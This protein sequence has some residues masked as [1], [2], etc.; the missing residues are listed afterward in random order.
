MFSSR[1]LLLVSVFV[2]SGCASTPAP[3]QAQA[4]TAESAAVPVVPVVAAPVVDPNDPEYL[5]LNKLASEPWGFRRDFWNT[6]HI[7]LVDWKNW[8]RTRII[9]NPTRA[10]FRY[11]KEHYAVATVWYTPMEGANDPE[12]CLAKFLDYA[13]P[14][15]D[16]Y[17][18]QVSARE[19]LRT[20][21]SVGAEV[22]PIAVE[23]L[24]GRLDS[25]LGRNDYMGAVAAYQSFPGTCLV[26]GFAVVAT[27]HPGLAKQ[28]RDRWVSEGAAQL[29]WEKHVKEAPETLSR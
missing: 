8:Q 16:A 21:Q 2:V 27:H 23:L 1:G 6:L 24:S 25:L 12:A 7:P 5:A 26:E 11:G 3:E 13:S 20:T 15:A 18:I 22:K 19:R 9:T 4:P 10:S 14:I 17:G 29:V 28:I